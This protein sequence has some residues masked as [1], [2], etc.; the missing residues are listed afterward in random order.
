MVS[1]ALWVTRWLRCDNGP[2]LRTAFVEMVATE[3]QF[4]GQGF[5]TA[6]ME[7]LAKEI[8]DFDLAGLWSNYPEWYA[9]LGWVMWQGPL[10]IRSSEGL[11]PTPDEQIMIKYLPK[12]PILAI[13]K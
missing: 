9:H 11:M 6:V 5:A 4:Q 8:T 3:P 7:Q 12:S 10:F 1:H 13:D 2:L